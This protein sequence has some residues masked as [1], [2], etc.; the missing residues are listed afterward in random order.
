MIKVGL[1]CRHPASL[2]NL[3]LL[4]ERISHLADSFA[5]QGWILHCLTKRNLVLLTLLSL[6]SGNLALLNLLL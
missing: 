3:P 1:L 2:R 6:L 5:L 4:G